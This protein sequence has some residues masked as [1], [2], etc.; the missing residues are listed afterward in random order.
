MPTT[1]PNPQEVEEMADQIMRVSAECAK[2]PENWFLLKSE[3][4]MAMGQKA[5]AHASEDTAV[6]NDNELRSI[7]ALLAYV[8]YN[9]D[10]PQDRVQAI[11]EAKF[12]VK[13]VT[14]LSQKSYDD[15]VCFLV[16]LCFDDAVN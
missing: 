1:T 12:G 2:R 3:H 13:Q 6:L 16:N 8:S 7:Y 11:V 14:Q 10:V 5:I 9:Q 4:S 15:V